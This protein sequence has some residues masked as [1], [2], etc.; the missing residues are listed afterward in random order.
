MRQCGLWLLD[1]FE[2]V[3]VEEF[4]IDGPKKTLETSVLL[5]RCPEM[6][7]VATQDHRAR[8]ALCII[9]LW[10]AVKGNKGCSIGRYA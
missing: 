1:V 8:E 7:G 6:A 5:G 3:L 10:E 4:A 2:T 9:S